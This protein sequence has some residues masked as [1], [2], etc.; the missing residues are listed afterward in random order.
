[1]T[2]A[3]LR[4]KFASLLGAD[5]E[6][7]RIQADSKAPRG[8]FAKGRRNRY[9]D[10]PQEGNFGVLPRGRLVILDLDSHGKGSSI[11]EQVLAFSTLLCLDLTQTLT[12]ATPSGGQHY[13]LRLPEGILASA[14]PK[15]TLRNAQS[16][17]RELSNSSIRV[18]ADLRS[19]AA[20]AYVV[21]PDSSIGDGDYTLAHSA[22]IALIP[23]EGV[24]NL[25]AI[26]RF[27]H[28]PKNRGSKNRAIDLWE[29]DPLE[30]STAEELARDLPDRHFLNKLDRALKKKN[31][32]TYH[33]KR[34]FVK[35]A[36]HCCYS[37]D[38]IAK[39]CIEL[40]VDRDSATNE[41]I[42][43]YNLQKDIHSFEPAGSFHGPYC[44]EGEESRK[45]PK[46]EW[47]PEALDDRLAQLKKDIASRK[48]SPARVPQAGNSRVLDV[49]KIS[50]KLLAQSNRKT[51]PK[52]YYHALRLV[53][54]FLQPLCNVGAE[55][56]LLARTALIEHTGLSDSQVAQ[57]LRLLRAADVI[58]VATRQ[59]TG[60]AP[61][62]YVS[63]EFTHVKLTT[64]LRNSWAATRVSSGQDTLHPA[65]VF[66]A[67]R[68]GFYQALTGDFAHSN[69]LSLKLGESQMA[70]L[71][72]LESPGD[73]LGILQ[74]YL[75]YELEWRE[76]HP[77]L[78]PAAAPAETAD[79]TAEDLVE[80]PQLTVSEGWTPQNSGKRPGLQ[81]PSLGRR[82]RAASR[83]VVYGGTL[84]P[85][86]EALQRLSRIA[87]PPGATTKVTG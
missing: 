42:H 74:A 46:R 21:G 61:T 17:I 5:A 59:K 60:V 25:L 53:D 27:A 44:A 49:E 50:R 54:V 68:G 33:Q 73:S 34:A 79:E 26:G 71:G 64:Y 70:V 35:A 40:G 57:A 13:Y 1:M 80:Y 84:G 52:Q 28:N 23:A 45:R 55:K 4:Q 2:D 78:A 48:A 29:E 81:L 18:D 10:P 16:L 77:P 75:R 47:K 37:N 86:G 30:G 76:A 72:E 36:L 67:R 58:E 20:N 6:F 65:L 8:S 39:A 31:F 24:E 87:S 56:I 83:R 11:A 69:A 14:L 22:P 82:N 43:R 15:A 7:L 62:Y 85:G 19:A 38:A 32:R 66:D 9:A 63:E 12:V 41:R 51:P 3:Q